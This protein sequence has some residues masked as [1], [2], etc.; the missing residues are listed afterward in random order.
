[1]AEYEKER[2]EEVWKEDAGDEPSPVFLGRYEGCQRCPESLFGS[3]CDPL[4]ATF[5]TSRIHYRIHSRT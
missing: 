1:M 5:S 2:D 3:D 4:I